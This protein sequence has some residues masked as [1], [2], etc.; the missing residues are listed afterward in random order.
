MHFITVRFC[1]D[2]NSYGHS[3]Y[4][5]GVGKP[6]QADALGY[7]FWPMLWGGSQDKIDA[8]ESAMKQDG[9]GTIVLG[10]NE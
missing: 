3:L 7:D 5:W 9:L 4:T 2:Q 1:Q 6:S 8:F 10:F